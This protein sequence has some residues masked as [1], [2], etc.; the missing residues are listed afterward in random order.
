LTDTSVWVYFFRAADRAEGL[1]ALLEANEVLLHP[2]VLGE[3]VLG[4]LGLRRE[5]VIED[6]KRLPMAPRVAA[7]EI[8]ELILARRLTGRGI[9]WVDAHLLAAALVAQRSSC[10][11]VPMQ[12]V[13]PPG[14]EHGKYVVTIILTT[15]TADFRWLQMSP[16]SETEEPRRAGRAVREATSVSSREIALRSGRT[17]STRPFAAKDRR[18]KGLDHGTDIV[19]YRE[20]C[21]F[22]GPMNLRKA[23][24]STTVKKDSKMFAKAQTILA[25]VDTGKR[26]P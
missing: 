2:W 14:H 17:D 26:S 4:G 22:H 23:P 11:I 10:T 1:A 6:L 16:L 25:N 24:K 21:G 9:G 15:E 12:A 7:P 5:S 20:R 3:L 13:L 8:L 19:E 18:R